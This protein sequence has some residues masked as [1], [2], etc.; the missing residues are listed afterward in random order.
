MEVKW[1]D[2]EVEKV[3]M[4][5]QVVVEAEEDIW[6]VNELV[7]VEKVLDVKWEV[8]E[9]EEDTAEI[10]EVVCFGVVVVEDV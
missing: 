10:K 5:E 9:I 1:E 4:V 7:E 2:V 6:V 8:L 3:V